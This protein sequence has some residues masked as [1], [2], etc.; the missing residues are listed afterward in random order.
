[1][2]LRRQTW[3]LSP[4]DI[5]D[6]FGKAT[7]E[8]PRVLVFDKDAVDRIPTGVEDPDAPRRVIESED[9]DFTSAVRAGWHALPEMPI[10]LR[11]TD[12]YEATI[13]VTDLPD[14]GVVV[15]SPTI[16]DEPRKEM[17]TIVGR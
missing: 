6:I 8:N 15:A 16:L 14:L 12:T 13:T 1:M 7:D 10:Q 2:R 3:L 5:F 11:Y 4:D 17:I 9:F